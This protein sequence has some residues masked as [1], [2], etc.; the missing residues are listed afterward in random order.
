[1]GVLLVRCVLLSS[2]FVEKSLQLANARLGCLLVYDVTSRRSFDNVRPWLA[3][4]PTHADT[5]VSC[6]LVGGGKKRDSKARVRSS[7][8]PI[9]CC[10]LLPFYFYALILTFGIA[11]SFY[12]ER[13]FWWWLSMHLCFRVLG[14]VHAGAGE[15]ASV[16]LG[17]ST[18]ICGRRGGK[19][20]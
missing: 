20:R 4:L 7:R 13:V 3:Y 16:F 11:F 10:A 8:L 5:H 17:A 6:I 18:P 19:L 2:V 12:S 15:A 9:L 14:F 1:M